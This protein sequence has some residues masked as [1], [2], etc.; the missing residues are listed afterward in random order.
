[1][2]DVNINIHVPLVEMIVLS[3]CIVSASLLGVLLARRFPRFYYKLWQLYLPFLT[4]LTL[5][6]IF[7]VNVYIYHPQF[8]QT[9]FKTFFFVVVVT[10][11]GYSSG[12]AVA[13]LAR[14]TRSQQL[15]IC[16]ETGTRTV[17]IVNLLVRSSLS[18]PEAE[19]WCSAPAICSALC[20]SVSTVGACVYRVLERRRTR[21]QVVEAH[22]ELLATS[23]DDAF[24]V[25]H[26][27]YS[28]VRPHHLHID[29]HSMNRL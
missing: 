26:V 4:L 6:L 29:S 11:V 17:Y 27:D 9:T 10:A 22:C 3:V 14:L 23:T 18:E 12:M 1:M 13:Y 24:D 5:I 2:T 7:V 15:T 28:H 19:L 16:L 20:V 21:R 8:H 25:D